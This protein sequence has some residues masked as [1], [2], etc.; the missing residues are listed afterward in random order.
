M[1]FSIIFFVFRQEP[2]TIHVQQ[3]ERTARRHQH[4]EIRAADRTNASGRRQVAGKT[5]IFFYNLTPPPPVLGANGRSPLFVRN[6]NS[7][8][9]AYFFCKNEKR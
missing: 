5:V 8:D 9:N 3:S 6:R 1:K 2:G 4:Q 7:L